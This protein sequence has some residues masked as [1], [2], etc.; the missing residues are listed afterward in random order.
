M[1]DEDD[2]GRGLRTGRIG[3]KAYMAAI[4]ETIWL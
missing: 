2:D 4:G 3:S 1:L